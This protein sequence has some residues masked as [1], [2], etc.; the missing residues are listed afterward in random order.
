MRK[1]FYLLSIILLI[2]MG[3]FFNWCSKEEILD[4]KIKS[5]D[6]DLIKLQKK[7]EVDKELNPSLLH[8][9]LKEQ[10]RQMEETSDKDHYNF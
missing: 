9:E 5:L 10:R 8:K 1:Y 6:R 4:E 3:A 2:A 7:K